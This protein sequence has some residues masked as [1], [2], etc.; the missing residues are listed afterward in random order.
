MY[1]RTILRSV[2]ETVDLIFNIFLCVWEQNFPRF[3]IW[4]RKPNGH[5]ENH[6]PFAAVPCPLIYF[7]HCIFKEHYLV[8]C[9]ILSSPQHWI[10]D[11]QIFKK[12][13]VRLNR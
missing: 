1:T 7:H 8:L 4:K 12:R 10:H 6:H 3:L 5:K 11:S 9:C 13:I 2:W